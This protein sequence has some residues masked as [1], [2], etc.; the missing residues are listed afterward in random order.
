MPI[1]FFRWVHE[2]NPSENLEYR[3]GWWDCIEIVQRLMDKH[4]IDA[5]QVVG[6]Y[7]MTTPPPKEELCMPI[8][9]LRTTRATILLKCDFGVWPE[10][11]TISVD[12]QNSKSGP[13]YGLFDEP[14][15]LRTQGVT[16]FA[17]DWVYP[18]YRDSPGKFSCNLGDEWDVSV[19][20]QIVTHDDA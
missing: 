5:A 7:L 6:T 8:V 13:T 12:R 19:L 15:D 20:I 4:E 18:S 9:S 14:V 11:W 16:G 17:T 3:K 1:D 2:N 10:C